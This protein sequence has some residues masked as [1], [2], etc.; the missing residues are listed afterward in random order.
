MTM[1]TK[2]SSN[3]ALREYFSS[4]SQKRMLEKIFRECKRENF[5]YEYNCL[6][7]IMKN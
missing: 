6:Q 1:A 2:A 7:K 4:D 3:N 5:S